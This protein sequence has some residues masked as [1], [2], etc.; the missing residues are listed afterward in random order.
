MDRFID[1][2]IDLE[3]DPSRLTAL[4][5]VKICRQID[6]KT[7]AVLKRYKKIPYD[8]VLF[9]EAQQTLE[10]LQMVNAGFDNYLNQIGVDRDERN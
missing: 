4:R 1:V 8:R 3:T 6:L 7:T 5:I 9:E 10:Y 2:M